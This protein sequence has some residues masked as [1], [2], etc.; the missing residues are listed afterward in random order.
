VKLNERGN[1]GRCIVCNHAQRKEID[2]GLLAGTPYKLLA[3]TYRISTGSLSYH[4][5]HSEEL[6]GVQGGGDS[7]KAI[8]ALIGELHTLRH[9]GKRSGDPQLV[10]Q[11]SRELRELI[12][13][14]E[15]LAVRQPARQ[16]EQA[17]PELDPETLASMAEAV[18]E[19]RKG[20]PN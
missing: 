5:Q 14:R 2:A 4:R 18:L 16:R 1:R 9:R 13:L 6:G 8:D 17:E 20:K 15:R 7:I 19:R 10:L 12:K 11:A 3:K